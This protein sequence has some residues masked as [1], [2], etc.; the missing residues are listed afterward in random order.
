MVPVPE[1]VQASPAM[2]LRQVLA[3]KANESGGWAYYSGKGS[4]VEPTSWALLALADTWDG[5]PAAW[6]RFAAPHLRFLRSTQRD[7]GLLVDV[8]HAPP[9]FTA[10]GVAACVLAH[11]AAVTALGP[12]TANDGGRPSVDRLLGGLVG[13]KGISVNAPD[14]RQD[15]KLQGWPWMPDTFSWL[16]PTCWCVLALKKTRARAR[17]GVQARIDEADK[18]ILNRSCEAGGWNFGNASA[19]GQDL[20]PYVPTTALG[21][22]ALQDRRAEAVVG[23]SLAYLT[24]ARVKEPSAM[25]L[26]LTA[27][28]LRIYDRAADDVEA[29]LAEDADRAERTGNLQALAMLVYALSATQHGAKAMRV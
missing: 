13:V 24:Q 9:N 26:A 17:N 4:R 10:N 27:L 1:P 29:R 28:C 12:P 20:R 5:E 3:G 19:L 6:Q 18:L 22:I 15:N 7:D 14:P 8:P 23:R 21:L 11:L 16:E 25:A 2:R